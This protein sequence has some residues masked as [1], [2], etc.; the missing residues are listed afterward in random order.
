MPLNYIIKDIQ[1]SFYWRYLFVFSFLVALVA[2]GYPL[3]NFSLNI[4]GEL[5]D[6]FAHTVSLG[7]WGHAL[8]R[9]YIL[10][11]PFIPY[12]TMLLALAIT[13]CAAVLHAWVVGL[14]KLQS[15]LFCALY[16]TFPQFSY[17]FEFT[18]QAETFALGQLLSAVSVALF[19][20]ARDE[21]LSSRA[22]VVAYIFSI[23][24]YSLALGI[25]QTLIFVPPAILLA[26]LLFSSR[27]KPVRI[28][29]DVNDLVFCFFIALAS[30]AIYLIVSLIVQRVYEV[31]G[32]NY[33]LIFYQVSGISI[34]EYFQSVIRSVLV[35][36][37]G[38]QSYGL[39][40]FC[41]SSFVIIWCFVVVIWRRS[42]SVVWQAFLATSILMMPLSM[43]MTS[44]Y[45][46]PPRTFVAENFTLAVL[47]TYALTLWRK[48]LSF[49]VV[50]IIS[51]IHISF[52]TELFHSDTLARDSDVFLAN[53]IVTTINQQVPD[54]DESV[55]PVYFHGGYDN[56]HLYTL[57]N[58]EFFGSSFFDWDGG[59]NIRL[60]NFFRYYGIAQFLYADEDE[61]RDILPYVERLPTWPNPNAITYHNGVLIVKLGEKA[62]WLPFEVD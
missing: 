62:G 33:F 60:V 48:E 7:R 15:I 56:S 11:E 43:L 16:I 34:S 42:L 57:P 54:F 38:G 35:V 52:I 41:L 20:L 47:L 32:S 50:A 12:F 22:K 25:Y 10:P 37:K 58:S 3:F 46:L 44:Q 8:L 4:D 18:N 59:N 13:A 5:R 9:A 55:M 28:R 6:N 40:T 30:A 61:M 1:N 53:R 17:Q 31:D 26:R 49:G 36:L 29:E 19:C 14:N 27:K 24:A 39:L 45:M 23:V 21:K 2:Y 51:V